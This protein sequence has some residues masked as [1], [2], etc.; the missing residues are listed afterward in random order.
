ML[1]PGCTKHLTEA[2]PHVAGIGAYVLN[3]C[4]LVSVL[5]SRKQGDAN[6]IDSIAHFYIADSRRFGFS[7][8]RSAGQEESEA[9]GARRRSSLARPGRYCR[10]RSLLRTRRGEGP[11]PR[12]LHF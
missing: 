10:P 2:I 8:G 1:S 6:A 7:S 5:L 4:N 12:P 11:A 3:N 9:G